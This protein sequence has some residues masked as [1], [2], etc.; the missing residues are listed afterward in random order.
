VREERTRSECIQD[1]T[2][3]NYDAHDLS[4]LLSRLEFLLAAAGVVE[5]ERENEKYDVV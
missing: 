5:V 2:L 4:F 3:L 1:F